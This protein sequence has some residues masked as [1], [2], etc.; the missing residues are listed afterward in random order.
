MF[1]IKFNNL[2]FSSNY[3]KVCKDKMIILFY[4]LGC[5]SDDLNFLLNTYNSKH[6]ILLF[7]LPG[8]NKSMYKDEN[9]YSLSLKLS[10]FLK[11]KRVKEIIFFSHSIG[12]I[13]PII[14]IKQFIKKKIIVKNFYNYEGNLTLQ[15]TETLTK[16]TISFGREEFINNKFKKLI[17]RCE[18]S[19]D[20]SINLWSNSLKKTSSKAF[21]DLSK[22]C[23]NLSKTNKLLFFF[24]TFFKKKAYIYGERTKFM[25]TNFMS[26][27]VCHKI[28]G[29]GHFAYFDNKLEFK[30][31]FNKLILQQK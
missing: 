7:E 18:E 5:C 20:K 21:F 10:I 2:I 25:N 14:L 26:G 27:L 15:D 23:V 29:S 19:F 22:D 12:G 30:K 28:K 9:F 1:R 31:M 11:K 16:K 4:G 3:S 8:H 24:K 6:Q 17:R 13:I